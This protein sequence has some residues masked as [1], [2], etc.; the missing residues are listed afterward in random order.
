MKILALLPLLFVAAPV[1]EAASVRDQVN[2]KGT[3]ISQESAWKPAASARKSQYRTT[4][5]ASA[6][7]HRIPDGKCGSLND[8]W[9]W[10]SN[11]N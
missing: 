4:G 10:Q 5:R 7:C 2:S 1:A 9:A 8:W 6:G 3:R 11:R